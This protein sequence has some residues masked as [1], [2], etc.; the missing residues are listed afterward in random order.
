LIKMLAPFAP[1]MAE[2]LWTDLGHTDDLSRAQW[3]EYSP[4]VAR[5]DRI[6]VAVQVNGK[7]RSRI[8]VSDGASQEEMRELALGDEKVRALIT[9]HQVAK[10]IVVPGKLVNVV[11][12]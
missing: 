9:G 2:E 6:E 8:Y 11:V 3:P 1:H 12:K 5:E 7:L 10:V 4:E